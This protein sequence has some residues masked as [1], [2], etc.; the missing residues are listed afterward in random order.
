MVSAGRQLVVR[1]H[2][3]AVRLSD[4]GSR[5]GAHQVLDFTRPQVPLGH[6]DASRVVG[7]KR[8]RTAC[9]VEVVRVKKLCK[10]L[11]GTKKGV[12]R[13]AEA[14]RQTVEPLPDAALPLRALVPQEGPP[15]RHTL[16]EGAARRSG[17]QGVERGC[18]LREQVL[19]A[20]VRSPHLTGRVPRGPRRKLPPRCVDNGKG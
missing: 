17:R 7:P 16:L 13:V 3:G 5:L 19:D 10:R 6:S 11:T 12:G 4:V 9:R 18:Q 15:A 2:N 20:V 8:H 14:L 1:P